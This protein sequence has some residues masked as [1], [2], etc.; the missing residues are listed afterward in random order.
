MKKYPMYT[1]LAQL[2][3]IY[4]LSL[5]TDTFETYAMSAY[6]K[7]GNKDYRLYRTRLHPQADVDGGWY[8]EK[9]CNM[10]SIEAITLD[11]E[12]AQ[13]THA[14]DVNAGA[15][16]QDIEQNIERTKSHSSDFYISGKFVKYKEVADRIYFN[17]P[18]P[19]VNLLYKG[20]YLDENGLPFI[21]DKELDAIVAY[22]VY[23]ED[24][25]KARLTKD[26]ST[27]QLAQLEYQLW[28]KACSNA[29]TPIEISQN[30]MNE[31]LDVMTSWDRHSYGASS[32]KPIV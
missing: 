11:Y 21:N 3:E 29:R 30:Q 22:C 14:T 12:S 24:M 16:F 31:I 1:A 23:V 19:S 15:R 10:D 6:N 18:Y 4:G 17:S 20:Q 27:Y 25:K 28:Q 5:E 26:T 7:I 2:N 9:P 8:V 13:S 32:S